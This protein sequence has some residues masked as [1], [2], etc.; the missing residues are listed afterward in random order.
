MGIVYFL[1]R[2]GLEKSKYGPYVGIIISYFGVSTLMSIVIHGNVYEDW[3]NEFTFSIFPAVA[4]L[5]I[6]YHITRFKS[7]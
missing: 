1:F 3:H 7:F 6:D 2:K 5:A 4:L